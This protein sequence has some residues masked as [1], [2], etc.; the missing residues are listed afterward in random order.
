MMPKLFFLL[1]MM[2]SL[3]I[4]LFCNFSRFL[5]TLLSLEA[6]VLLLLIITISMSYTILE[7]FSVYLFVLSLSVCEAALG[8]T[9]LV[10]L[11][12]FKGNDMIS[13]FTSV[14]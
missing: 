12:K 11:V 7:S 14:I 3:H 2:V 5:A 1:F 8:L 9:L 4:Y 10:S 6:M 13:N